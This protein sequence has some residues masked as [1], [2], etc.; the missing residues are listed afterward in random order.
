M[1]RVNKVP[2]GR[3]LQLNLDAGFSRKQNYVP[4]VEETMALEQA[5]PVENWTALS[6]LTQA[7]SCILWFFAW[8]L[9]GCFEVD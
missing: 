5:I 7:C 4:V 3:S 2:E 9:L 8:E 6:V 1:A